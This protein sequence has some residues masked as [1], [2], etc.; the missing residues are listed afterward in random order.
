M[1]KMANYIKYELI[2]IQMS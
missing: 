1:Q 2:S